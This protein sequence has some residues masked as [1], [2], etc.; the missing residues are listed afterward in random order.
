LIENEE[1]AEDEPLRIPR[2]F[3]HHFNTPI[4]QGSIFLSGVVTNSFVS[5]LMPKVS[6]G[7]LMYRIRDGELEFLLAHPGGPFWRERDTGAWTIPKGEIQSGEEPLAAARREFEEEVGFTSSGQLI[8]LTPITQK[9][10]KV[11]HAWAFEGDCDPAAIKSNLFKMEWPPKSGQFQD[12]PEVDRAAFFR[13]AEARRK[14]NPAQV[15]LL[16][17]LT[18]KYRKP[19]D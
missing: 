2:S 13:L 8:A 19:G 11:V 14:I 17:E 12:C 18:G 7:L 16:E 4:L 6:A 1:K 3:S 10:G 5:S 9:S 15:A